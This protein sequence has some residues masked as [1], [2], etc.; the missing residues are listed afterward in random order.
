MRAQCWAYLIIDKAKLVP[1]LLTKRQRLEAMALAN[2][3]DTFWPAKKLG[4]EDAIGDRYCVCT[5]VQPI[6]FYVRYCGTRRWATALTD[7][8]LITQVRRVLQ[9]HGKLKGQDK[10]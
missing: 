6:S 7:A 10:L 5:I 9:E 4:T 3:N 8:P 2:G 1:V